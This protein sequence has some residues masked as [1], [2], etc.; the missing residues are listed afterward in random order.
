MK[1]DHLLIRTLIKGITLPF[2]LK[3]SEIKVPPRYRIFNGIPPEKIQKDISRCYKE[4]FSGPPWYENWEEKEIIEKIN[5]ELKSNLS[6]LTVMCGEGEYPIVGFCWGAIIDRAEICNRIAAVLSVKKNSKFLKDFE[7]YL[8]KRGVKKVVYFDELGLLKEGRGGVN[9]L[10][11]LT[12]AGFNK[13]RKNGVKK[14]IFWSTYNSKIVPIMKMMGFETI[15]KI[16]KKKIIF[17]Y[18]PN[19]YPVLKIAQN[20]SHKKVISIMKLASVI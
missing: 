12:L 6:F 17:L 11:F 15:A 14:A 10:R 3:N 5:K 18:S 1:I 9:P 7:R 2:S 8:K 19:C 16:R 20:I 13:A 4:L